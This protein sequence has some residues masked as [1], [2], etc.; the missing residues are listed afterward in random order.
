MAAD[1]NLA[2]ADN[3]SPGKEKNE[4]LL[5]FFFNDYNDMILRFEPRFLNYDEQTE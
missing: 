3:G 4:A 5:D 2:A 1:E